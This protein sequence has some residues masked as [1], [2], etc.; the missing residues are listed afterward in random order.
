ML[1]FFPPLHLVTKYQTL[2]SHSG[3][4]SSMN[5]IRGGVL[6]I[7]NSAVTPGSRSNETNPTQ[8]I[9]VASARSLSESPTDSRNLLK[10]S[11]PSTSYITW[12]SPP[13]AKKLHLHQGCLQT[14]TQ[15][16][17]GKLHVNHCQGNSIIY[18]GNVGT[19]TGSLETVKLVSN[20]IIS[21][22]Y[23]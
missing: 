10:A 13:T 5:P 14:Q 6:S 23:P 1:S 15:Q 3:P 7:A 11:T 17:G 4:F 21:C 16:G 19:K 12:V 20:S 2:T 8:T 22:P 18:P 9:L